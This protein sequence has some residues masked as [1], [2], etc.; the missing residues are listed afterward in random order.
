MDL[1][2]DL[3][4]ILYWRYPCKA[5]ML[6]KLSV[7]CESLFQLAMPQHRAHSRQKM[8]QPRIERGSDEW[9]SSVITIKP[10]TLLLSNGSWQCIKLRE[11]RAIPSYFSNP[12]NNIAKGSQPKRKKVRQPRIERGADAWKASILPLNY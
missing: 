12:H 1:S 3:L 7:M 6:C 5:Q 9:K 8:R 10:L 2:E 4:V 11:N